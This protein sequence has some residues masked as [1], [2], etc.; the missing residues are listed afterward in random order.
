MAVILVVDDEVEIRDL[1]RRV[2]VRDGHQV[3]VAVHGAAALEAVSI[4]PYDLVICNVRM[5]VMDGPTFY[6]HVQRMDPQLA[7]R[8]LFCTGDIVS[9]TV[10]SFLLST[11]QAVLAK[12]F[13][14]A[15][16][17]DMVRGILERRPSLYRGTAARVEERFTVLMPPV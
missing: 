2:L 9:L 6:A 12:P 1:I 4:H 13:S 15:S 10:R 7:S 5:P 16:L 14:I 17:C 11:G 8:F 3:D